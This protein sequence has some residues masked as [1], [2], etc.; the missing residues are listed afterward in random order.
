M[1]EDGAA[2]MIGLIVWIATVVLGCHLAY[3]EGVAAHQHEA[4]KVGVAV[5]SAEAEG[6]PKFTW[7]A[8][9]REKQ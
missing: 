1:C 2:V 8:P 6:G 5:W 7:L 9:V 3:V 4:V